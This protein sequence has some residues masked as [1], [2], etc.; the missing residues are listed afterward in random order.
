MKKFIGA[1]LIILSVAALVVTNLPQVNQLKTYPSEALK[2]EKKDLQIEIDALKI[3]DKATDQGELSRLKTEVAYYKIELAR[4]EYQ[5]DF[6]S[7]LLLLIGAG[8]IAFDFL[9][10]NQRCRRGKKEVSGQR[11]SAGR[12]LC[13]RERVSSEKRRRIFVKRKSA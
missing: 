11:S 10:K 5:I 7:V 13:R 4:R 3:L 6:F 12:N 8:L 1:F 9:G 2:Q